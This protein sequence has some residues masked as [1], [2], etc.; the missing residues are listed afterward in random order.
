[1]ELSFNDLQD[2]ST[3]EF[4]PPLLRFPLVLAKGFGEIRSNFSNIYKLEATDTI[5]GGK[6]SYPMRAL[7][8]E[9]KSPY[10]IAEPLVELIPE[11]D[12]DVNRVDGVGAGIGPVS[13]VMFAVGSSKGVDLEALRYRRLVARVS[14]DCEQ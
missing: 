7:S 3:L 1:M 5:G 9:V 2:Y 12:H 10:P 11:G 6:S 4:G 8:N 13:P 14:S